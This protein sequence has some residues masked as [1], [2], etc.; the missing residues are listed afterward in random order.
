MYISSKTE[1]KANMSRTHS[2]TYWHRCNHRC[3]RRLAGEID[4]LPLNFADITVY[5]NIGIVCD[6][7]KKREVYTV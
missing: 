1:N 3:K 5:A 7:P 2:L 6:G 4:A